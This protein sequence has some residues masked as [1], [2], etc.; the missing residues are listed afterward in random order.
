MT[1]RDVPGPQQ[2]SLA[3][4]RRDWQRLSCLVGADALVKLGQLL[5]S[6]CEA[7]PPRAVLS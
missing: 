2:G 1:C 5:V 7:E 6:V 4:L 3:L